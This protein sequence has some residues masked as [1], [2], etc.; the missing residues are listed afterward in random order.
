MTVREVL[1]E[2]SDGLD[3]KEAGVK[4]AE[5]VKAESVGAG[6]PEEYKDQRL[7]SLANRDD[8]SFENS[9]HL[10]TAAWI[11]GDLSDGQYH[12][13]KEAFLEATGAAPLDEGDV[14]DGEG[15]EGDDGED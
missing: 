8:E 13:L 6:T 11:G 1:A 10:V 5:I 4:I 3:P 7:D 2:V 14:E 12:S 9:F 15:E